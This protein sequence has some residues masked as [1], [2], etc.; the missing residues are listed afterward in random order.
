MDLIN[1]SDL[2]LFGWLARTTSF[3][4]V[5]TLKEEEFPLRA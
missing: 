3:L 2:R 1:V 4:P 5:I